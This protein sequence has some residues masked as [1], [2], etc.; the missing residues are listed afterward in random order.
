MTAREGKPAVVLH[1]FGHVHG[2]SGTFD[3]PDTRSVNAALPAQR[4][5]LS[6]APKIFRLPRR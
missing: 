5:D 2:G 1:V 3:S 4:Y 6:N